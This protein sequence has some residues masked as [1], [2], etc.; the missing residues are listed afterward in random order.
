MRAKLMPFAVLVPVALLGAI[1]FLASLPLHVTKPPLHKP[2]PRSIIGSLPGAQIRP[3]APCPGDSS[4][5]QIQSCL[6]P[7]KRR[8]DRLSEA[9]GSTLSKEKNERGANPPFHP[10]FEAVTSATY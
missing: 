8:G 10:S 9:N 7:Q 3:R 1:A 5:Y 6:T 2:L 4:I